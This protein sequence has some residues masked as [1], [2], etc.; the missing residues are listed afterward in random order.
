MSFLLD[1]GVLSELRKRAPDAGVAAW[2]D[3]VD[4]GQLYLSVLTVGEIRQGICRLHRRDQAQAAVFDRWLAGV[5]RT[6]SDRVVPVTAA[7]A[8]EW[9]RL[10]VPDPVPVVDGLLAATAKVHDWTLVTRNV[11]DVA[12]TGARLLNPFTGA[13]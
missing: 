7:V 11:G 8:Q 3:S 10:N 12:G 1:A 4:S 9:G 6:Y 5:V 2:F 13:G